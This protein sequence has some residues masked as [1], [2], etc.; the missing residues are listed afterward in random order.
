MVG[1]TSFTRQ[2]PAASVA[3]VLFAVAWLVLY[4]P[5]YWHFADIAW[6]RDEN[7]H[8]PF[9]MAIVA[10]T[11]WARLKQGGFAPST[12][13]E[14]GAGFVILICG[15]A[16]FGVGRA[17]GI[18]LFT[19][20]SQLPVALGACLV[21]LGVRGTRRLWF[22][23]AMMVYLIIWPGWLIDSATAPLKIFVSETV[24]AGLFSIGLPVAQ[25]GAIIAAG[26]YELLVA[27]ACAGLNS[28]LALTAIGAVY[29]YA[30]KR[31]STA[32]NAIVIVFLVPI[33]IA[34]N[35]IR[36]GLL[37]LITHYLG[38]DA[39]QGFLHDG[40]GLVMFAVALLSVFAVEALASVVFGRPS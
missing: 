5:V 21:L 19:S 6:Q 34:A 10:G 25:S 2:V 4:G 22:P 3:A 18:E 8:V 37:V 24:S 7:G 23:L 15:L 30:V 11:A 38:Y 12:P 31:T 40:A 16:L 1:A 20:A 36:V 29:L 39:G 33:A 13:T 17:G 14:L 32:V 28:L 35:L 9:I 26:P 27:D